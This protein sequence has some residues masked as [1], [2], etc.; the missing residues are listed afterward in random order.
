MLVVGEKE[1]TEGK[2][3]VRRQGKGDL[4]AQPADEFISMILDEI[5]NRKSE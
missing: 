1:M 3:S 4:G 2:L 5:K